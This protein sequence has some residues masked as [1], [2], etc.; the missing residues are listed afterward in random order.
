MDF[1]I[2]DGKTTVTSYLTITPSEHSSRVNE[3]LVLD[4][5]ETSV[6]L[7]HLSIADRDLVEEADYEIHPGK[8]IIKSSA[9]TRPSC[10]LKTTVEIVPETNTQLSGLYK[11]G[12]MYCSQCEVRTYA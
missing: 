6:T 3:D 1:N 12:S 7:L 8:L 4:G 5:D 2:H 9:L 11:S 10:V